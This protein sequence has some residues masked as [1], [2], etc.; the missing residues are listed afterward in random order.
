MV[1]IIIFY[2]DKVNHKNIRI[3]IYETF[4]GRVYWAKVSYM[5]ICFYVRCFYGQ[6]LNQ[7]ISYLG[8]SFWHVTVVL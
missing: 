7:K 1:I 8:V 5:G 4:S 6:V 2:L 3:P